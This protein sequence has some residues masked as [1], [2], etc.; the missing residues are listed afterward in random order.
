VVSSPD[1]KVRIRGTNRLSSFPLLG[2]RLERYSEICP[3][4][5]KKSDVKL[6]V[7]KNNGSHVREI[8]GEIRWG[9]KGVGALERE[10]LTSISYALEVVL[11]EVGACQ[12]ERSKSWK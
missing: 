5:T 10:D 4:P 1:G 11:L 8:G 9:G 7:T 3:P 2:I 6:S 12:N